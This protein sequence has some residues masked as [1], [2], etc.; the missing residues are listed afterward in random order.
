MSEKS[1][2]R[3]YN[4]SNDLPPI[5][6]RTTNGSAKSARMAAMFGGKGVEIGPRII[7]VPDYLKSDDDDSEETSSAILDRQLAAEDGASI[8]Y[9]TCSWQKTAA[10]LFSEYICLAIMSFPWSYS[11]LGLVPGIILTV[12]VAGLVLYTSLILWQFCL[13]HPEVRDV[14]DIG[15]TL[16]TFKQFPWLGV[17]AWWATAV[18]FILNNTFIQALHVLVGAEYLNTMTASDFIGGCRTVEFSVIVTVICWLASLPRTFSMMSK[19]GTASAIFT[20]ISVVL[21]TIFVAIQGPPAHFDLEGKGPDPYGAVIFNIIPEKGTTWVNGMAAFLNISYTFIGQITLPS[22][23]AEMRDPREFPKALWACTIA[24]IAVF[25]VVGGVMYAY[26]GQ[27]VTAPAFGSLHEGYKKI[28]FSFMIPTLIF[29]GCLYA[30]VT[31]RFVFFRMFRNSRHLSDHTVVGW[32]AWTG[33]LLVTWIVAFVISQVIPFFN[34]R[35]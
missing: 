15:Q 25:S 30:S 18:M 13:R 28:S 22:F 6:A 26:T 14:C 8:Q 16:F 27:Y 2:E 17:F 21:A 35:K 20:F 4:S 29:L 23:I 31:A 32:S 5:Y 7:P 19:L 1:K 9:R 24:E 12:V 10:L 3:D 11:I 34:S 33:I